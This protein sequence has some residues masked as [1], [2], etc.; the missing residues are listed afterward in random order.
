MGVSVFAD[1]GRSVT[2]AGVTEVA[3]RQTALSVSLLGLGN[4]NALSFSLSF[5]P[6]RLTYLGQSA[7]AGAVGTSLLVN[8]N[9]ASLGRL[10]L[11]LAKSPG[12]VFA[13]GSNE[14][15]RVLFLLAGG[16][17]TNVVSFADTP[18]P[19]E[20]VDVSAND[21]AATYTNATVV[22]TPL[23]APS[24][25]ADPVS[26]SIQPVTNIATNV[27]FSVT[28]GGSPPFGY[29]WRWNGANLAGAGAASLT[30]TN[31]G[32]AQAGNYDVVVT[33]NAG[34]VTSQV[35][36]L[37]VWP[38]LIPPSILA[39]PRSQLVSTGETVYLTVSLA[40]TPPLA[41]QWQRNN[42]NLDQA[43]NA[44]LVLTNITLDQAGNYRVVVTNSAGS[45]TS[46]TATITV[47]ANLRIVRVVSSAVATGGT[48]DVPVELVGL[49]DESA[50]GFSLNFDPGMLTF[51]S[52][53][54]GTGAAGA[55]L[56]VNTN[57][58]ASG[59][60]GVALT[61][62]AG[63]SFPAGTN[64]LVLARFLAG[65]AGGQT[66]LAFGDQPIA[67]EVADVL[68]EPRPA[69]FRDGVVNF[70]ATAPSITGD[71]QGLTVPIFSQAVF[72]AG[73]AGSVPLSF[74]WQWNG[75]NLDGAT[76]SVLTLANV[77][78]SNAG[79]YRLIVSNVVGSATSAVATLSVPRVLRAGA[80][81]G[82]TGNL[83]ELPV[84]LLAAG[85]ENAVGF[86]LDFDP[87]QMT[88]AGVAPGAAL[89]GAALNFNTNHPGHVGVVIAQ[90]D[91][92]VFGVGTQQVARI[93]FLLG[94]QAGTNVPAWSDAPITRDL[95]DTNA[96]SLAMQFL[97]GSV[98]IQLVA[99]QVAR[100]PAPK[101]AWIGDTV[102][103]D[104]SVTGS[105][106]MTFQWQKNG[107]DLP[108]A[109]NATLILT[110][111]Q[112]ADGA[113]YSVRIT[114]IAGPV[115][116]SSALLTVLTARPDLFV[117]EV[118]APAAAEAGQTVSVVWK[119]FNI[120]NADAPAGWWHSLSLA[121]D[122]AGDNPQFVAALP[123][124]TTLPAGQSLSVTGL[125]TMPS[126]I[127]GDRF[128]RV[129]ADSS[130]D[131]VE[132][133]ENNNIAIASQSTHVTSGDLVL[134]ALSTPT[135]A[136][137]GQTITVAWTVT[138]AAGS[139]A[140][141]PWQDRIYLG[142]TA[143]SLAGAIALLTVPDPTASLA[144]GAGY[145]NTQQVVL[146]SS[147]QISA[148]AYYLTAVADGLNNVMEL[149]RTNN[150]LTAPIILTKAIIPPLVA[151]VAMN[152]PNLVPATTNLVIRVQFN[153]S[154]DTNFIPRVTLTNPAA[155]VQAVVPAGGTWSAAASS[156]DTFTLPAITFAA[157]MD[158]TNY[159]WISQAQDLNGSL[160]APTNI[161]A[162]LVDVTP[163][164]NPL[165]TLSTSNSSSAS[166]SWPDYSAP[167]DLNGFLVYLS[168]T[169]FASVTSLTA[170]SS[171]GA[172]ARAF[173]YQGLSLDQ[174][175]YAA[176]VGI[177][178]AG[179]SSP[180]VTPLAFILSN[181]LPPPVPVLVSAVGPSS[182]A[183]SWNSYDPSALLGFA[184][185]QLYYETTNFTSV[186]GHAVRQ[187]LDPSARSVQIDNLDRTKSWFFAV[188]GVNRNAV[189]NPDVTPAVWTDPYSGTIS[190][191]MTFGGAGQG[192]IDILQSITVVNNAV[193]TILP[194][195][196]LRFAP[197]TGLTI[198]Q[199]SLNAN[200]TPLDPILFTSANDQPGGSP[201]PGDWNGV[202]L[203]AGAGASLLRNVFVD[204]GA[205]LTLSN[206]APIV[207]AFSALYNSPAGLTVE[208]GAALGATN[209]LLAYNGIGAQQ[210][211]AAQ[212]TL[213]NCSIKN[214]STNALGFGGLAMQAPGNWWGSAAV[215]DIDARLQGAVDRSGYLSGE[216][217]LSP[218]IG[219]LNNVFQVGAQT[220][221]LRLACRTAESM[222]ISE[223][224][225]FNGVFFTPFTNSTAFLLSDGGGQKTI[226]AQFRSLTGQTN[227]PVSLT[228]TYITS[229][230][231]IT[232]FNLFEG[233]VLTRPL[234]V[235][236]S[237]SALLG[238]ASLEFYVDGVGLATNAGATFSQRFDVRNLTSGIHRVELLA[239]DNSGNIATLAQNVVI[240]PTPPPV[241]EITTP[242]ADL[243]VGTNSISLS[244]TAEPFIEVRLF[245]SGSLVGTT[246][247]AADGSFSFADV[248]L[249]EGVNQFGATA[250]DALGSAGSPLRN[251]TLDTLPPA[252]LVMDAPTYVPGSG[253]QLT[254]HFPTTGKRAGSFQVFWS[255][256]PITNVTQA[257]GNTLVLSS[258]NT[259]VQGL[260]TAN[261][262][263]YVIG[264][265]EL[266]NSSPLSAPV[267]FAYDAIPPTFTVAFNKTSPVG[268]GIVHVVLTAS[269]PLNGLPSLTVQP[270]GSA[271]A[272]LP[273]TNTTYNTYEGDLNV[274]TLL[275]SG[276]VRLNVSA[277]DLAGNPFN[278]APAGLQLTIDVTP[279]VGT[280]TTTPLPPIQA[281]NTASVAVSLQLTEPS[282]SGS[283]PVLDF[284]PPIGSSIP[285]TLSGS[286]TN[287]AGTLT[288]T[289]DMGSGV[290]HFTLTVSDSVGNVG[291]SLNADGA[292]E[293]YNT[294]LPTPPGQPVHF[295]ASSLAGGR[296]QL[297]WDPVSNAEVY[298]VYCEAGTNYT[299]VPTNLV[300]DNVLSNNFIHLP[301]A[302]GPYR[303]AVTALRR[304]SEGTNSIVRVALSD[305]T[306]P[307][308]PTNLAVQLAATG[309][310]I[311]WLAGTG[312]TP[313]HFNVYRNGSLIS[314]VA[315]VTPVIDNP[316]RGVMAY[317]V[318]AVDPLG[319]EAVSD[320]VTFQALVGAVNN[321]QVLANAGQA[322]ALSWTASDATAVGFNV[323]RN[324][325]KQNAA[326]QPGT[327]YTDLLPLS[328][329]AVTYA[330]TALNATNAESAARSATVYPVNVGL[331]VNAAGGST[332]G[333]PTLSY[334]DDYLVSVSNL[335]AAA[336]LPLRQIQVQRTLSGSVPLTLVSPVNS[337][338][339]PGAGYSLELT[340]PCF[341]NT[342]PQSVQ[343]QA[344]QQTDTD[345]SS[346]IYQAAFALP[347]TQVPGGML[348]V[349]VNQSPLAGGLTPFNVRVF[350]RGYAPMYF[351]TTR[352]NGAQ[353]GD[354]YISVLNSQGQEV[355]RTPFNGTP[356]GTL[357]YGDVGYVM[358]PPGGSTSLTVPDVLV[359]LALA[360]NIVTFQAVV[361]TLFDRPAPS[362][363][364]TSG[365]LLG[366]MQSALSQ[367]PYYGTA[368]TAQQ[369][370]N[371]D[372]PII[373]TGQAIDRI[374][375]LPVPNV[376]LKIGFS[377]RG[378]GWYYSVTTDDSGNY[379]YTYNVP[380]GLAGSLTLWAAHPDVY[381]RLNQ[382]QVTIYRV[383]ASP[384][385]SDVRMSKNDT[386]PFNITLINPGDLSLSGF[387]VGFQAYQM[388][389]T[390][391]VPVSSLH[392]TSLLASGFAV[393]A[394]Q[395][396]T[397]TLQLAADADAPDNAIGVFTL[398]SAEGASDTFTANITLLP[399]VPMVTVVQPD[400]GY[401]EVSVDR[402]TLLSR[403]VTI[404]NGG[405]K[406]L[407]GVTILPPTNLTWM[408]LNLPQSP[409]GIVHLPDLPVGQSNTF[410][411]VFTPP[412]N[413][414]LG[415]CQDSL[416]ILGTNA[417]GAFQVNLYARVTSAN[418]GAVQFY[419]DDILG[420]DVPN[421][422]VRL[423]NTALQVE[424][425]S[426]QTDIN[427][428]V[429]ITNL[430][431]GDWSWQIGAA[432][433][434]PNVGVV[435]VAADQ[436]VSVSSRLN[437][438]LVTVNFSVTPVPYTDTYQIT[439]EQTFETH[440]PAPVLTLT[441]TCQQF[442]DVTPGFQA[443]YIVT[444]KNE[445]LIQMEDLEISG[446]QNGTA[447]MTPLITYVPLLLPQQSVDIP[448]T[449]SY[450]GSNAPA[451]Q[452]SDLSKCW[453]KIPGLNSK[454]YG[455][456][457]EGL[458]ALAKAKG[459]CIKDN[460]AL[461]LAG[462]TVI[463]YTAARDAL[464]AGKLA[465]GLATDAALAVIKEATS[466]LVCVME[467]LYVNSLHPEGNLSRVPS[468]EI[469][470]FQVNGQ[471]CENTPD[472]DTGGD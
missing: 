40:G 37:T 175:Y 43:T 139:P 65:N 439:I 284:G 472:Y 193:L 461:F 354:V 447:T 64:Q 431:E 120:G 104:V 117:S 156:N 295:Q 48:V 82:P 8:T 178:N 157:G 198:Q 159:V 103:F 259:T 343:V 427:G 410:T 111:V 240:S 94:Q 28:A 325:I 340:V 79:A 179:N 411:V 315:S 39:S 88:A 391:Q 234:T 176:V 373:I 375:H 154:M 392:G 85:N 374:T 239:R 187:S 314:T 433:H 362:G 463:A 287:W 246:Y 436:T 294:A 304:G 366:T 23:F 264:Y 273:L 429:T 459:R 186:A 387:T 53:K 313:D 115:S 458:S 66:T 350:N 130:N 283:T 337:A 421:A 323:Y 270:Y 147:P 365:P 164:P 361:S 308:A 170:V 238:M 168:N 195:T 223:D 380:P 4:E 370:Y 196:T 73:V 301:D 122:A 248:P 134:G 49:G 217:L 462:A 404:M 338:V 330:V 275:P 13:T 435:T 419:V 133:S 456:F 460:T 321:L 203:S 356:T 368:Q 382:V 62:Q 128:F 269:K 418:R 205:G 328:G 290:G 335:A 407:K 426:V 210:L 257:S 25:L 69:S 302:D 241:P 324:G 363:Q 185:F 213:V 46:Q 31:V 339:A 341:S 469:Q 126:T 105:K 140:N 385:S 76:G 42:S 466:S 286:G 123:F 442:Q 201:A 70:L 36:V 222:R 54:L 401:V 389:G 244:G 59:G 145:T 355:S 230:P 276:P 402:G 300:A 236:G 358:V 51:Q 267:Q 188:V 457:V 202:F 383:Y 224:S 371:N 280:V 35:A 72:Q 422:T 141:G 413:A 298:R 218:A 443:T 381:D 247:A 441:P 228:L 311:S 342:L 452:G 17:S 57:N 12:Q 285:I 296:V 372:Q 135:S 265:D 67:R 412:T 158:G 114:N 347:S 449:F 75:T 136:Q 14:L 367:T 129:Q 450:L 180:L 50:V 137:L 101:T 425:P 310:Q 255:T 322:P 454:D 278:G 162:I 453:P 5:D 268:V 197:G 312:E 398:T 92:A 87:A 34:A 360:S 416:T 299:I 344:A 237:A 194:G 33:N 146:P 293:I 394:G 216:P 420:L 305:R 384:H 233:E 190:A 227:S 99:P 348:D 58:L 282:Q 149:T 30:L 409:D 288:L 60:I 7:G 251:V 272:L 212:L 306:P 172:G 169:N 138:N 153:Q 142:A 191:N 90:P 171:L 357:F 124:P 215:A 423:R 336:S 118:S 279:P 405:L 467:T 214:N 291:H 121:S 430:Q 364:Q 438:S 249:V 119:L 174:P 20:V 3:G 108:G 116:S 22:I 207:D 106:P 414:P 231:N 352:G 235:S 204:Y 351:A 181:S 390:N 61:R 9:Q 11:A 388:K 152:Y 151:S 256:S 225:S 318:S 445:G 173:T 332:N 292:L 83:V 1:S 346:V 417:S 428:L 329:A 167:S 320:P 96:N 432:G 192:T 281:T 242:A 444:V 333:S 353:P 464:S 309:L 252:Q 163:P 206:C 277:L 166:M 274:T 297:T 45:A 10:G 100:Q 271:P 446:D 393:A 262:Y 263:F 221:N 97:P 112:S 266:N 258:M 47:S 399:A 38:A 208:N 455:G 261:Y 24:I 55:G 80:T 182:A 107:A 109:T 200:G 220:A 465:G 18:I 91:N 403:Q 81:N 331:L 110:N 471:N 155:S 144:A 21:L 113:N 415:S 245:R 26:L 71:P 378:Y 254:W 177:D 150:S 93:Q 211:G 89:T 226:F 16:D 102:T 19:R 184:G 303:Y 29:Q 219:A 127:L 229:G 232:S 349:S 32:L 326:P 165:L 395:Q 253:L 260:A 250:I 448:F 369:L 317:T 377:T 289:P 408:A 451:Q 319:N 199:G 86:S 2:I 359:P 68:A 434:S 327:A 74:Q 148:G 424:L 345:G 84:E 125:V 77:T 27:T 56:L 386:L 316:P 189:F 379:S 183:I 98:G 78:P 44:L 132:L 397:V 334:F 396:Q 243:I 161:L 52:L 6:T 406:D 376:P 95:A 307:P 437:Q 41:C 470:D 143:N 131:V 160:L 209:A 400:V 440:V 468:A 63:Q 15:V